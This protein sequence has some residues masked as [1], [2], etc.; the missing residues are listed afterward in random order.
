MHIVKLEFIYQ[1]LQMT[2]D[3]QEW[4]KQYV[5]YHNSPS[6]TVPAWVSGHCYVHYLILASLFS[7]VATSVFAIVYV[8]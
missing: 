4:Y 1:I 2:P 8:F 7:I 6:L 5:K 3:E